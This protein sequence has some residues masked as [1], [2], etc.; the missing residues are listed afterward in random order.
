MSSGGGSIFR[1]GKIWWVQI[2]VDGRV[3]RQSSHA[4]KYEV[5]KRLRD[6]LLGQKARGELGGHNARLTV[7]FLLD[8]FLKC[9]AVRVRPATLNIQSLVLEANLRPFFGRLKADK[10]T[11]E[12]LLVY[13]RHRA[14]QGAKPSTANRELSLLR[15]CLRTAANSTPPL[16]PITSIPRFPITNED[17]FARQG[18]LEDDAFQMLLAVLP[19][20]LAP[21]AVV[22]YQT[23]IRK[24][25]L[26]RLQWEQVDFDGRVIRLHGGETKTGDPRTVPMIAE[27][28]D[29]LSTAKADRDENWPSCP[30]VFHRLGA[31]LKDFRGAWDSACD[32]CH[33]EGLQFHDL[34]R[35][36]VR[37]LSRAG[38]P[39]RVIMAI[40]GHKT[41]AMFDRYNIVSESDLTDAAARMD[42]Y[43]AA[44][45][46]SQQGSTLKSIDTISDTGPKTTRATDSSP[47]ALTALE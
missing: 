42:A 12:K 14:D 33:L 9:L 40:T 29:V 34:R 6:R 32:R 38:V 39:E 44:K 21:I 30:W 11:T 27:M 3:I 43:R 23:G 22:A 13:R 28:Y 37:N 4:E 36:G 31:P 41:R 35:S 1:R 19:S 46:A 7:G 2:C 24:G 5:A 45:A 18:F 17:S 47:V 8:H 16:I 15:N 20:Y 25:E 26:L 10:I